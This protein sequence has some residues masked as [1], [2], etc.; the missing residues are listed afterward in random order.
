[1]PERSTW[2]RGSAPRRLPPDIP[3]TMQISIGTHKRTNDVLGDVSTGESIDHCTESNVCRPVASYKDKI[4]R[5]THALIICTLIR[6]TADGFCVLAVCICECYQLDPISVLKL[7][8]E[9][10]RRTHIQLFDRFPPS[11]LRCPLAY[12]RTKLVLSPGSQTPTMFGSK[13][14]SNTLQALRNFI[15][16]PV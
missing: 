10:A 7:Y 3:R 15:I 9:S 5:T 14:T 6:R 16:S 2:S 11:G 1:M 13:A 8:T 4:R 12:S